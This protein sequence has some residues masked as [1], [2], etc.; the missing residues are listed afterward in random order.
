MARSYYMMQQLQQQYAFVRPKTIEYAAADGRMVS[1]SAA[2]TTGAIAGARLHVEYENGTHVWVNRGSEGTWT[3][4][5]GAGKAVELPVS[6]WLAYNA[7]LYEMSANAG[8]RRIDY[9]KAPEY[10]FL[11][12]RGQWT[13]SGGLGASGSIVRR[14]RGGGVIEL[15]DIYGNGRIAFAAGAGVLKAYDPESKPLGEVESTSPRSGWREFKPV[16]GARSYVFAPA[17]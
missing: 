6:G 17:E 9:V 5:D 2:H 12:G 14:E 1:A 3:V 8:G 7:G 13:E 4:K 11:D 10:E 15:I 16:A